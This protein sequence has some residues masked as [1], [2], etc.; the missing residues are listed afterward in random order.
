M[1]FHDRAEP[2]NTFDFAIESA[3]NDG[4]K[5]SIPPR[6]RAGTVPDFSSNLPQKFVYLEKSVAFSATWYASGV[7]QQ[8][9][10]Q[11]VR[12]DNF[13]TI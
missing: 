3:V 13:A 5:A 11:L 7:F 1:G 12:F 10:G 2:L 6:Y 4:K 9:E 8:T